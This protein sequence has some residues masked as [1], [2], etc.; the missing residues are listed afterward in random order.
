MP[1]RQVGIGYTAP[2][3]RRLDPGSCG[4]QGPAGAQQ[5]ALSS[6][7][8]L[9]RA[10][11]PEKEEA[12][13][14]ASPPAEAAGEGV[15]APGGRPVWGKPATWPSAGLATGHLPSQGGHCTSVWLRKA[16]CACRKPWA[17]GA[18]PGADGLHL[19]SWRAQSFR[20]GS[21]LQE[22]SHCGHPRPALAPAL[23]KGGAGSGLGGL[24]GSGSDEKWG[25]GATGRPCLICGGRALHSSAPQGGD[26]RTEAASATVS[27]GGVFTQRETKVTH[28]G[29]GG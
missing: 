12:R 7:S 18:V 25:H 8:S 22:G 27:A 26:Q 15:Q 19:P 20:P 9:G 23:E 3:G 4:H 11:E 10:Q 28:P 21:W 29:V 24:S 1:A 16:G 5:V 13:L 14:R 2:E 6:G 17:A